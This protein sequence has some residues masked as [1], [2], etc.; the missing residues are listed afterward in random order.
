MG[1]LFIF[2][3]AC[4]AGHVKAIAAKCRL[5]Y[6]SNLYFLTETDQ[7]NCRKVI[8]SR[9][10]GRSDWV[11]WRCRFRICGHTAS[12]L[13]SLDSRWGWRGSQQCCFCSG[14]AGCQWWWEDACVSCFLLWLQIFLF[15][16]HSGHCKIRFLM[17]LK[18]CQDWHR[19]RISN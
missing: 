11:H 9:H 5:Q 16:Q 19:H 7:F 17:V 8:C 18:K 14:N 6:F 15:F 4:L 2:F 12:C 13:C 1:I 3:F 10:F